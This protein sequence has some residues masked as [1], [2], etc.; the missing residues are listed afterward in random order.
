MSL[1]RLDASIRVDGS[2]SREIADLVE[3]EWRSGHP[4]EQIVRR[5]I[6]T[7]PLPSTLWAQAAF[8]GYTAAESRTAEQTAA[9][10][11]AA[12]LTDELVA[13][14]ALLFAVPLYNYGVS[15]H[16]KTW[17]DVVITDPRMAAGVP[18]AIAGKPAVL[19]TVRGGAYGEGTPRHGWDHATPWMTHIL[20]DLWQLDLKVVEA[21]LTLVGSNPALD[22]FKD[23]AAELHAQARETARKHGRTLA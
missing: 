1:F 6:G 12:E 13:A 10:A 2:H 16:F 7:D 5:H 17:V 14:D 11:A 19:V 20:R 8:A 9:L 3:E 21:E 4:E 18:P 22:Q 23:L 15:Q